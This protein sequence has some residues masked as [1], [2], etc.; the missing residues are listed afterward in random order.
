ME[1][2]HKV[3]IGCSAELFCLP[4]FAFVQLDSWVPASASSSSGCTGD[5]RIEVQVAVPAGQ[6][7]LGQLLVQG[8]YQTQ[9]SVA[10]DL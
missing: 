10:K 1:M 2:P 7:E 4:C 6:L 9:P 8:M 5:R 3:I